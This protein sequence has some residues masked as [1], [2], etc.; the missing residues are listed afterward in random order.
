M[1]S[2]NPVNNS[3]FADPWNPDA[4]EEVQ[5]PTYAGDDSWMEEE[6]EEMLEEAG[7]QAGIDFRVF[8]SIEIDDSLPENVPAAASHRGYRNHGIGNLYSTISLHAD[9][10]FLDMP[11]YDQ[12]HVLTHEGI[13]GLQFKGGLVDEVGE[14]IPGDVMGQLYDRMVNGA[15][16]DME[17]AT[18]LLAR[19][20]NPESSIVGEKFRFSEARK[21]GEEIDSDIGQEINNSRKNLL[22][23]Y[24]EIYSVEAGQNFYAE[25]GNFAGEDYIAVVQGENA[26][27][28]GEETVSDYLENVSSYPAVQSSYSIDD[29]YSGPDDYQP[30]DAEL[31]GPMESNLPEFGEMP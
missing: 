27:L 16:H 6:V 22:D 29:S 30:L 8:D 12:R 26:V 2:R 7:E 1:E 31:D 17:G 25:A 18:E 3:G 28:D 21:V 19:H 15:E 10:D 11:E 5:G 13:H 20:L 14:K 4:L 23:Q 9:P 24:R